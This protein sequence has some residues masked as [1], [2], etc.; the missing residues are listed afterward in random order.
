[1]ENKT[2]RSAGLSLAVVLLA[3]VGL[4]GCVTV[5]PE[6]DVPASSAP[7]TSPSAEMTGD[8]APAGDT[9][10]AP[11]TASDPAAQQT[12]TTD[13]DS[14][15]NSI[16]QAADTQLEC[17][18]DDESG[19]EDADDLTISDSDSI[20]SITGDCDDVIVTGNNLTISIVEVDDLRIRGNNN[21]IAVQ[22][23]DD[24]QVHGS[25]NMV[26]WNPVHEDDPDIVDRGSDNVLRHDALGAA[27]L[28]F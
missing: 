5:Q 14:L 18:D 7:I 23:L 11:T 26:G 17:L 16:V 27:D 15:F 22:D 4:S 10:A 19:R 25:E 9:S 24:L 21:I 28:S 6:N 8:S 13:F 20:I 3:S 2:L 1:M 12:G